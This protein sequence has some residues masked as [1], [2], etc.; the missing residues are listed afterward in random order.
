MHC[1]G[2]KTLAAAARE[3]PEAFLLNTA[4]AQITL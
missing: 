2:V 1:T 4:G 3:M